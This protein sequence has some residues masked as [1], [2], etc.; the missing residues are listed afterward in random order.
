MSLQERVTPDAIFGPGSDLDDEEV[1]GPLDPCP[2]CSARPHESP[3]GIHDVHS[4]KKYPGT[5]PGDPKWNFDHCWK[6]GFRP[7]TNVAMSNAELRRQF[8]AFKRMM[9][10]E[11]AKQADAKGIAPPAND[12][13][14]NN[15]KAELEAARQRE[16][17]LRSRLEGGAN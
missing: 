1:G 10:D 4:V 3:E 11:L 15:L 13:E 7:G 12:E 14:M 2:S 9:D 6:C 5:S 8:L 16:S 17:E